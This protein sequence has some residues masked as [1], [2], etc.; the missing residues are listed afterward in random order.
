MVDSLLAYAASRD[1]EASWQSHFRM[2]TTAPVLSLAATASTGLWLLGLLWN[3]IGRLVPFRTR[4]EGLVQ[5]AVVT[6]HRVAWRCFFFQPDCIFEA[7]AIVGWSICGRTLS[8]FL[9]GPERVTGQISIYRPAIT[10]MLLQDSVAEHEYQL[11]RATR[12]RSARITVT[13][14]AVG[15]VGGGSTSASMSGPLPVLALNMVGVTAKRK[16][17]GTVAGNAR[18]LQ[19]EP[20]SSI[21]DRYMKCVSRATDSVVTHTEHIALPHHRDLYL[22]REFVL[23]FASSP[24]A[25]AVAAKYIWGAGPQGIRDALDGSNAGGRLRS[26][27]VPASKLARLTPLLAAGFLAIYVLVAV[28]FVA[29]YGWGESSGETSGLWTAVTL[30][31]LMEDSC[32]VVP[33]YVFVVWM[34]IPALLSRELNGARD[35]LYRRFDL[36][37]RRTSGAMRTSSVR[38]LVQTFHPVCRAARCFPELPIARFLLSLNDH[39][40]HPGEGTP[41][42][43]AQCVSVFNLPAW[44]CDRLSTWVIMPCVA[45][46]F[47]FAGPDKSAAAQ[48]V[49]PL[50]L[51][52]IVLANVVMGLV[53]RALDGQIHYLGA[54][55]LV[56]MGPAACVLL[57][58]ATQ[59]LLPCFT[60]RSSAVGD[61]ES[62][63]SDSV[64][65]DDICQ[66]SKATE[67]EVP[68]PGPA[69]LYT[70]DG[71]MQSGEMPAELR[72]IE[73]ALFQQR[74]GR[75]MRTTDPFEMER[76]IVPGVKHKPVPEG[77]NARA[78][79]SVRSRSVNRPT[80]AAHGIHRSA[81]VVP[82]DLSAHLSPAL[83]SDATSVS[84]AVPATDTSASPMSAPEQEATPATPRMTCAGIPMITGE[85]VFSRPSSATRVSAPGAAAGVFA[86]RGFATTHG[87]HRPLSATPIAADTFT[88]FAPVRAI[89]RMRPPGSEPP[90]GMLFPT[91]RTSGMALGGGM[92]FGPLSS[93]TN[94]TPVQYPRS[95][96]AEQRAH[97]EDE[98][99]DHRPAELS[100]LH[101]SSVAMGA[102]SI[103]RPESPLGGRLS[104]RQAQLHPLDRA[105]VGSGSVRLSATVRAQRDLGELPV[106]RWSLG[107]RLAIGEAVHDES[108]ADAE[109]IAEAD[110]NAENNPASLL[111]GGAYGAARTFRTQRVNSASGVQSASRAHGIGGGR[112]LSANPHARTAHPS[113]S[114]MNANYDQRMQANRSFLQE[115]AA[116]S[117]AEHTE[118]VGEIRQFLRPK[119][120][121]ESPSRPGYRYGHGHG[122]GQGRGF[123]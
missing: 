103:G 121:G 86:T 47:H 34:G 39:D 96:I 109:A 117:H 99:D 15:V 70:D 30:L 13:S 122:H 17:K 77:P 38:S 85:P 21:L 1:P 84:P 45:A 65:M 11:Q 27:D 92:V 112:S 74:V 43:C 40:L 29:A 25:R 98:A 75:L 24:S 95:P 76:T 119:S 36:V 4:I 20:S 81:P 7:V 49:W 116:Q 123:V 37:M 26:G 3:C 2:Y 51:L 78:D 23:H 50:H 58:L 6:W 56:V 64:S 72:L 16:K 41:S 71:L 113:L 35:L 31:A 69:V 32:A 5:L 106:P 22:L 120:S 12:G 10:C 87:A 80:S 57:T 115:Q 44:L 61:D 94:G 114:M 104:P 42:C 48:S 93:A 9:R 55:L 46:M 107:D 28:A 102:R 18:D 63:A 118:R 19:C 53:A 60:S 88:A 83:L 79:V 100:G 52:L 101:A 59:R 108:V 111:Y 73:T 105:R 90:R 33:S 91:T 14:P 67:P 89:G 66:E 110:A 8:N 82:V 62:W 54:C 97:V 68:S